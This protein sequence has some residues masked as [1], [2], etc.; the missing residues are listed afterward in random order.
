MR[1]SPAPSI[2]L[3]EN[4]VLLKLKET[5][6]YLGLSEPYIRRLKALGKIPYVKIG[7]AVRFRVASLNTWI[8][9]R[10]IK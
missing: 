3:F 9:E 1:L 6:Q 4:Q 2:P 8:E 5:A 7:R 10:E